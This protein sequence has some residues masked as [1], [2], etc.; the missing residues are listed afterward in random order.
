M[1]TLGPP[2]P[3]VLFGFSARDRETGGGWSLWGELWS[4][5]K[6]LGA[7]GIG[8]ELGEDF[9]LSIT[10]FLPSPPFELPPSSDDFFRLAL[11][12]LTVGDL[13][14]DLDL[15][16]ER[17]RFFVLG[18]LITGDLLLL[19]LLPVPLLLLPSGFFSLESSLAWAP[20]P[21]AAAALLEG[22]AELELEEVAD[23]PLDWLL[24]WWWWSR[25]WCCCCFSEPAKGC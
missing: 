1:I 15:E 20:P 16:L 9:S 21:A 5:V 18:A 6:I 11:V 23:P 4:N 10:I 13:E 3:L 2:L 22:A 25:L 7:L 8:S 24:W 12:D 19:L 14:R 17:E